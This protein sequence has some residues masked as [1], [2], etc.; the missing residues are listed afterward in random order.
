M[1]FHGKILSFNYFDE[2]MN[3]FLIFWGNLLTKHIILFINFVYIILKLSVVVLLFFFEALNF[4]SKLSNH[5][6]LL[7]FHH[8]NEQSFLNYFLHK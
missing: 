4:L 2:F 6:G 5:S 8:N 7:F 3:I 1:D